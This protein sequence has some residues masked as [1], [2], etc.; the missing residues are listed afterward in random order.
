MNVRHWQRSMAEWDDI[1]SIGFFAVIAYGRHVSNVPAADIS[2][3]VNF[4][5]RYFA[6]KA[7]DG[8]VVL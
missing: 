3:F 4:S 2:L 1:P 8:V 7:S 6:G 5:Q